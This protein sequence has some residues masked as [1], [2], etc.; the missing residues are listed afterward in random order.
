MYFEVFG[1]REGCGAG[2]V[3]MG[4]RKVLMFGSN[5]YLDLINHP[6]VKEAGAAGGQEVRHRVQRVAAAERHAGPARE[7]G[8]RTGGFRAQRSGHDL[9]HGLS[10]QLRHPFG[11]HGKGRRAAVR[12]QPARQPGGGGPALARRARCG[13]ATT[14][15]STWS[16]AWKIRRPR[17][18]SCWSPR[19]SSAWK[20]T[21]PT[22]RGW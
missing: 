3:R 21:W 11:P 2:E 15:W 12:P 16:A 6:K 7:G 17:T 8:G 20:A 22:C 10:G 5:D 19:A 14:T 13:S 4:R 9:R 1:E 18:A